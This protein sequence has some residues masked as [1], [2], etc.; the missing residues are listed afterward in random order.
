MSPHFGPVRLPARRFAPLGALN[1]RRSDEALV[2]VGRRTE[3]VSPHPTSLPVTRSALLT[4]STYPK[5]TRTT[6]AARGGD[7]G[8]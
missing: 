7:L 1:R 5:Y 4:I 2:R 6:P 3:S 8:A